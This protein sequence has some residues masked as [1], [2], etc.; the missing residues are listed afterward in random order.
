MGLQ[1]VNMLRAGAAG[2][3]AAGAERP[4]RACSGCS[5]GS[6][7]AFGLFRRETQGNGL[8][9]GAGVFCGPQRRGVRHFVRKCGEAGQINRRRACG[10]GAKSIYLRAGLLALGIFRRFRIF[11]SGPDGPFPEASGDSGDSGF[12]GS[13]G[14]SG[15]S[16]FSGLSGS[17]VLQFL[18]FI[19]PFK[20]THT[21]AKSSETG[22]VAASR[23]RGAQRAP[24]S[25][26]IH[27][28]AFLSQERCAGAADE[29]LLRAFPS[30][31]R[32]PDGRPDGAGFA[33]GEAE[34]R[35][36]AH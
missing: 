15:S 9:C 35:R 11:R 27:Q 36:G 31:K 6:G 23:R 18:H 28:S 5:G 24:Q 25:Y 34:H 14:S 21:Y 26:G 33:V 7:A 32:R 3:G 1:M 8:W 4:L 16:G 20:E 2:G 17:S 19:H 29:G 22:C 30:Q 10:F 12:S 13:S